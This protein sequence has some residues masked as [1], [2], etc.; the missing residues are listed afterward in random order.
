MSF[1]KLPSIVLDTQHA[2]IMQIVIAINKI[3]SYLNQLLQNFIGKPQFSSVVLSNI[4]IQ[5]GLNK[6]PHT[7]NGTLTGWQVIGQSSSANLY[8]QQA[9]NPAATVY[10]YLVSDQPTTISLLVF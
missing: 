5:V 3:V 8:D 4:S 7:L 6:I 1:Q 9:T 10:L 2:T